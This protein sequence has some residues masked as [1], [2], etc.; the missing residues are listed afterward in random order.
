MATT[1]KASQKGPE[2]GAPGAAFPLEVNTTTDAP[3]LAQ[4]TPDRATPHDPR[5]DMP[6]APTGLVGFASRDA[7]ASITVL[8]QNA[9]VQGRTHPTAWEAAL[10]QLSR[11]QT[12]NLHPSVA[13]YKAEVLEFLRGR[14]DMAAGLKEQENAEAV[15]AAKAANRAAEK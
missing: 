2:P 9:I 15:A 8:A 14:A 12:V 5:P 6:G 1:N 10:M 3:E 4:V 11:Q 7:V 13:S